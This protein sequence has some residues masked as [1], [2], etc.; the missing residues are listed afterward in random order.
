MKLQLDFI[1]LN[2]SA[3]EIEDTINRYQIAYLEDDIAYPEEH[4]DS[5]L[6]RYMVFF[7]KTYRK[8][9][10]LYNEI[11]CKLSVRRYYFMNDLDAPHGMEI[12]AF[13][14]EKTFFYILQN[15]EKYIPYDKKSQKEVSDKL[16]PIVMN[17]NISYM[18]LFYKDFKEKIRQTEGIDVET[19]MAYLQE[20]IVD[21][22]MA[23]LMAGI[24]ENDCPQYIWTSEKICNEIL[25]E[26]VLEV[27]ERTKKR[28]K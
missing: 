10:S 5:L 23:Y 24:H 21:Y 6:D 15:Y 4:I 22:I 3:M 1:K 11:M 7:E 26:P 8:K 12:L 19:C 27:P 28:V 14:S 17:L 16:Y 9:F 20:I 25:K 18:T 13:A 2:K